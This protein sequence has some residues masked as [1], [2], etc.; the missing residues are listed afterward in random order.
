[1]PLWIVVCCLLC[2]C[3]ATTPPFL[4]D[5]HGPIASVVVTD[6]LDAEQGYVGELSATEIGALSSLLE[7]S[8]GRWE[9]GNLFLARDYQLDILWNDGHREM[10]LIGLGAII[11]I[12]LGFAQIS[13]SEADSI[14]VHLRAS[15]ERGKQARL[16]ASENTP[17]SKNE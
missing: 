16:A 15:I 7:A 10:L 6:I 17:A 12:D 2:G 4:T 3:R 8:S 9:R 13:D 14:F 1:M 5:E 11:S